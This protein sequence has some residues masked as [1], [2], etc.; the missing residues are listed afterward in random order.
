MLRYYKEQPKD[1]TTDVDVAG[2]INTLQLQYA[3]PFDNEV[4]CCTFEIKDV[5]SRV[6]LFQASTPYELRGWLD[7]IDGIRKSAETE[8]ETIKVCMYACTHAWSFYYCLL[9]L[10]IYILLSP[11]P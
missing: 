10:S 7:T 9:C 5:Q 8:T 3:R 1:S 11:V 2:K 6:F 4:S